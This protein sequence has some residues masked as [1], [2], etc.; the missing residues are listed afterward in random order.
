MLKK[1]ISLDIPAK[2]IERWQ[3]IANILSEMVDIPAAL[4]MRYTDPKIQVFVSSESK[5]NPYS[6]GDSQVLEDSG[7]Y[8]EKVIESEDKLLVPNALENIMW[9]NNPDVKLNMISYLGFPIQLPD[10]SPFGT[11]CILDSKTNGYS[12]TIEKMMVQFK[13]IIESH[14]E[15][16]FMNKTLGDENK[17][18]K[19]YL[20]ELQALRGIVP[21]CA[22]C[23]SI[24]DKEDHWHPIEE[25]L[26]NNPEMDLSHTIC[27]TCIK[28]LYP[29]IDI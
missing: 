16:L 14:L 12:K 27:P 19:D 17:D 29:E 24:R 7:L 25:Y 5:D 2:V 18:L 15:L 9:K 21:I 28:K 4:I 8:C 13:N 23:K 10:H 3:E 1:T 22:S 26:V 6:P 11:L 20:Q